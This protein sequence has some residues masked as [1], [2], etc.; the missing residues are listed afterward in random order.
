MT[1]ELEDV[2]V[3]LDENKLSGLQA[4]LPL[5]EAVVHAPSYLTLKAAC[6][7]LF[8]EGH[9]DRAPQQAQLMAYDFEMDYF[10]LMSKK[11]PSF[12]KK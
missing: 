3:L 8:L 10:S 9:C 2:Y 1:A 6:G 7:R 11:E 12:R 4:M 5:L